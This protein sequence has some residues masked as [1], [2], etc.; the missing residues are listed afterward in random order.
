MSGWLVRES[1]PSRDS[2]RLIVRPAFVQL[3]VERGELVHGVLQDLLRH[4]AA[5]QRLA[6]AHDVVAGLIA[7][8]DLRGDL[9]AG[10]APRGELPADRA[11]GARQLG[12]GLIE[13]RLGALFVEPHEQ[14]AGFHLVGFLDQ[15]IRDDA[16]RVGLD[17]NDVADDESIVGGD[18]KSIMGLPSDQEIQTRRQRRQRDE[19]EENQ[20][21]GTERLAIKGHWLSKASGCS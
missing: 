17:R 3:G 21:A 5:R 18:P 7:Q 15:N 20:A 1:P 4:R 10:L 19:R 9:L 16:R 13:R 14:I 2:K 12:R 11:H 8:R 6:I